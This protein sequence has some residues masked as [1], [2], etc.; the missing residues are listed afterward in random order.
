LRILLITSGLDVNGALEHCRLLSRQLSRRGHEVTVLCRRRS[1]LWKRLDDIPVRVVESDM[2]RWPLTRPLRVAAW[3]RREG[4]D[5]MHT[6]MSRAHMY[7]IVLRHLTGIPVLATAHCQ[8]LQPHW[9]ANDHVI[10]NSEA[11]RRYLMRV[12]RV[13]ARKVTTV[14]CFVDH[15]RFARGDLHSR[16]GIRRQWRMTLEQ[17]VIGVAGDV[18]RYKGHRF[19]FSAL[20]ALVREFPDLRMVV[21][22]RFH[23]N[24]PCT[25]QL[26]RFQMQHGLQRRVKW[27]G[28]RDN[29]HQILAALDVVVMPSLVE[30]MGMVALEAMA[31]G[32]PVVATRV[33]GLPE[34]IEDGSSGLL[35]RPRDAGELSAA[36]GRI[37]R[38]P[39]LAERL[40]QGGR[41]RAERAFSA[42]RLTE[43]IER[44]YRQLAD[45]RHRVRS[46]A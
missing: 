34:L 4:F 6:H 25:Q 26:R 41:E 14:H 36:V 20:P 29:M 40:R 43:K 22:G 18:V 16:Q 3:A 21:V 44:V 24:E 33:G 35:V 30:S 23:R 7:G 19:L 45:G 1:W 9:R 8:H 38:D 46:A 37:L 27:I 17:P 31:A 11:T 10:A 12:N 13:P 5:V 15:E 28:R 42:D 39:E 2:E 32:I